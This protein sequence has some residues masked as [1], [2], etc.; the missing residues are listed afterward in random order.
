MK[1]MMKNAEGIIT[2]HF[3]SKPEHLKM[4]RSVV[5]E[6]VLTAGCSR[7][8]VKNIVLAVNEA[9]MNIIQHAY[10]GMSDGDIILE[11]QRTGSLLEFCLTDYGSPVFVH[12]VR[13][14]ALDDLRQ[15]GL[16]TYFMDVI[17]D[18]IEYI[19]LENARGTRLRMVKKI[20]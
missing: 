1:S 6:A 14:R 20:E 12:H 15:G 4:V 17:M 11:I 10:K 7:K 18:Y 13:P 8:T 19:P 3:P 5:H 16:G 9:C 2:I